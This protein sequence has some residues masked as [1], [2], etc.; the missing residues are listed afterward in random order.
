MFPDKFVI[1]PNKFFNFLYKFFTFSNKFTIVPYRFFT[2][3]L[4]KTSHFHI[5]SPPRS[6]LQGKPGCRDPWEM[7]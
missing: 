5:S 4:K 2:F 3:P 1:D 6:T 7:V